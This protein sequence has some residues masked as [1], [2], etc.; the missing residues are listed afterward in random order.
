M[1][2][3]RARFGMVLLVL[4]VAGC[5]LQSYGSITPE[6]L[7]PTFMPTPLPSLTPLRPP[8]VGAP[9]LPQLPVQ[10]L[11]PPPLP[12]YEQGVGGTAPTLIPVGLTAAIPTPGAAG[13]VLVPTLSTLEVDSR[14]SVEARANQTL[15]LTLTLNL[16]AGRVSFTLQGPDGVVWQ[17]TFSVSETRRMEIPVESAGTYELMVQTQRFE[18]NYAIRWG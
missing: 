13:G 5:N 1:D 8:T 6:P 14:Y 3:K 11:V 17:E 4:S 16:G 7:L 12:T 15:I 10:S 18:G 9:P 2:A